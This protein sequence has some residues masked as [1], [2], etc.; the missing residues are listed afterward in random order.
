V[1]ALP[2]ARARVRGSLGVEAALASGSRDAVA[3]PPA[4]V[5][6]PPRG[7]WRDDV[8]WQLTVGVAGIAAAVAAVWVTL[9]AD[10]LRHPEWLAAQKADFVIGPVLTGLYW[11]RQRPRSPFGPLLIGWGVVGAL[12]I[13]QSSTEGWLFS[14]GLFWEKVFGLA[15]YV[16]ILAFPSGRLDRPSRIVLT[17]GV[18]TVLVTATAIQLLLPQV[19]AGGSISSCR[20]LCP[21]NELAIT[22]DPALALDLFELFRY[23]VLALALVV[24]GMV[25]HRFV[26]G[27]P[28]QRRAL[29]VGTP[30]A[31]LFLLCEVM[32]QLLGILS[33][34]DTKLYEIVSWVFVAARAGVWYG[35]LFA[36]VAAKLFAAR[37]TERLVMQSLHRPSNQELEVMLREPLGDPQLQLK[38]L[39]D[40]ATGS[41]DERPA[42]EAGP[43][44][45]VTVLQHGGSPAVAIVHDAQL[46][47]DPELLNAAG[48]IALL[49]AENAQ[50]DAGWKEA[51]GDLE[52]SRTRL[53][54][55]ADE[56]R[57]KFERNLHDGVQQQLI[58]IRILTG[59]AADEAPV[60]GTMRDS[61]AMIDDNVQD[62]LEEVRAVSH[63]LYPPLLSAKGLVVAL[64]AIQRRT[65]LPLRLHTDGVARYS[66]DVESAV[67]YSC[68]EAIQNATKH[69]GPDLHIL[70]RL[71]Q[72]G[73]ELRFDVGDDGAGFDAG[74]VNGTGLQ[75][76][77]D[78]LGALGGSLTVRTAPGEGTLVSGRVPRAVPNGRS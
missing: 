64:R 61:L 2:V 34:E 41:D 15:T 73:D 50:L 27:T 39:P 10:F 35:F 45:K 36:L 13:L 42:I 77:R 38:V 66:P 16:L 3:G 63:G 1:R 58:A 76:M 44:R 62:A 68:L 8:R 14:I 17:V 19:G 32:Y 31:L 46:D 43:G 18:V 49:A 9:P 57:R 59:L 25:I 5:F 6:A 69:G 53:V 72:D 56:E 29:A 22:S 28:P 21:P 23:A 7:R 11:M 24:A 4:G 67:Y 74:R 70:V 55:A 26:T 20:S 40:H 60:D 52:R 54:R 71:R 78:R 33:A 12:Y 51:I 30:V 48:A 65:P 37:A 75:N 47:D